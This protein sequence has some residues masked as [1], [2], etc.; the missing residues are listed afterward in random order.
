MDHTSFQAILFLD[1]IFNPSD[2]LADNM[3]III[4]LIIDSTGGQWIFC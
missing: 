1:F 3:I 4:F 2:D